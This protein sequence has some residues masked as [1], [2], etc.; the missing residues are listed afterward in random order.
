MLE[1]LKM[2]GAMEVG[3]GGSRRQL[4]NKEAIDCKC[5]EG[6]KWNPTMKS[7]D[8]TALPNTT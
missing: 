6:K 2:K 3:V 1:R 5:G 8:I 4:K 7:Y